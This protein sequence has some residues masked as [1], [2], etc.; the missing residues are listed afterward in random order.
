MQIYAIVQNFFTSL[1]EEKIRSKWYELKLN[2]ALLDEYPEDVAFLVK[3]KLIYSIVGFQNSTVDGFN[4]NEIKV[5][6]LPGKAQKGL[7]IKKEG[8][9]TAVAQIRKEL[10]WNAKIHALTSK[11]CEFEKWSYFSNQGLVPV[12]TSYESDLALHSDYPKDQDKM[13]PVAKL[14]KQE[15]DDLLAYATQLNVNH[16]PN[17][18][19]SSLTCAMQFV[20]HPSPIF[21]QPLLQNLN[22]QLNVHC[23]IRLILSDG[24]VY[25]FGFGGD[26]QERLTNKS[27]TKCLATINGQ[28]KLLDYMEFQKY[29]QR[30]VTTIPLNQDQAQ[31]ILIQL[32]QYR[33]KRVRFNILKQNCVRF[34]AHLL[35]LAGIS[36]NTRVSLLTTA[37]RCL[38]NVEHLPLEAA[39]LELI[40]KA[41]LNVAFT[42]PSIVKYIFS[43]L[44]SIAFYV[45]T[46]LASL[47][48]NVG[49][50]ALGGKKG[51][52]NTSLDLEK[53]SDPNL[54]ESFDTL[55]SN[56]FDDQSTYVHHSSI[57]M[58]WQL[59]QK[60]TE[61]YRYSGQP[62][63]N[64]LPP[65]SAEDQT[66]SQQKKMQLKAVYQ[67]STEI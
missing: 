11:N 40:K 62:S 19:P 59:N 25:S 50:I 7:W 60:T 33:A 57:F 56:V 15:M 30:L 66:F 61:A 24:S 46:Q 44:A 58:N 13:H 4:Q 47:F 5:Q 55:V 41:Y 63:M 32:N 17:I 10:R 2:P 8:Q 64:I 9:W 34:S 49:L 21:E 45:P 29:A 67:E 52:E 12:H 42:I 18:A 36:L 22:A 43:C 48:F 35:H 14:S 31:D 16:Q 37:W 28:P 39:S 26:V 23:G 65:T 51:T 3:T 38:P 1:P 6:C 53:T 27:F 20:T 54:L